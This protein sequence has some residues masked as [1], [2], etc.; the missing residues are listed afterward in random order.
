MP[1]EFLDYNMKMHDPASPFLIGNAQPGDVIY[2]AKQKS[3]ID[4]QMKLPIFESYSL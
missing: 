2:Q 3:W 1:I 4:P